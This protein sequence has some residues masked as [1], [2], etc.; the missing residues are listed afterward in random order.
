MSNTAR[1]AIGRRGWKLFLAVSPLAAL[2]GASILWQLRADQSMGLSVTRGK[3]I[4]ISRARLL[5]DRGIDVAGWETYC[6]ATIDD[7]LGTLYRRWEG[8]AA[9]QDIRRLAPAFVIKVIHRAPS[10]ERVETLLGAD[11]R[12]LGFRWLLP[13]GDLGPDPSEDEARRRARSALDSLGWLHPDWE[14]KDPKLET[15]NAGGHLVRQFEWEIQ[16]NDQINLTLEVD[17]GGDRIL[18]EAATARKAETAASLPG[19]S[20]LPLIIFQTLGVL[21]MGV[22][23][24]FC[25]VRYVQRTQQKEV[26][27]KR[28]LLIAAAI[29]ACYALM[30]FLNLYDVLAIQTGMEKPTAIWI[31]ISAMLVFYALLSLTCGLGWGAGEGDVRE[32]YPGKLTSVDVLTTGR[33]FSRNT[34]RAFLVGA[35]FGGWTLLAAALI[36]LPFGGWANS[37]ENP[38]NLATIIFSHVPSLF[39][40]MSPILTVP[41]ATISLVLP[42]TF[43]HRL[44]SRPLWRW[45]IFSVLAF[46]STVWMG[47]QIRPLPGGLLMTLLYFGSMLAAFLFYDLLAAVVT[48]GSYSLVSSLIALSAW[49]NHGTTAL[50]AGG[51]V[52]VLLAVQL[53]FAAY[54]RSYREE[55]VR[56]LYAEHL[57]HRQAMQAEVSAARQ[58]QLTLAPKEIPTLPGISIA[59]SCRPSR[60]V[61]GDFY[62]FYRIGHDRIGVFLA[63][64]GGSGLSSALSIA[65]AK[66]LLLPMMTRG[67]PSTE[68]VLRLRE[69]LRPI[70]GSDSRIGLFFATVDASAGTFSYARFGEFP[71]VVL[72]GHSDST[73]SESVYHEGRVGDESPLVECC[74]R[75]SGGETALVFTDGLVNAVNQGTNA[76]AEQWIHDFLASRAESDADQTHQA[77]IKALEPKVKKARRLGFDDDLSFVIVQ[78]DQL[79]SVRPGREKEGTGFSSEEVA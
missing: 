40:L 3:A 11:G 30:A 15:E 74:F 76:S 12:Y 1:H 61:G 29:F 66:G 73:A 27:H 60:T 79:F 43:A 53:Y 13:S 9:I 28:S 78:L 10:N 36:E 18:G 20:Q 64:G 67:L 52:G 31:G 45:L 58:A 70:L 7:S 44:A 16:P 46:F 23:V 35:A 33:L 6:S 62:D 19:D 59:A 69:S 38:T 56:P 42:L 41:L 17:V 39:V 49:S 5:H 55:E 77:F 68:V 54:G 8:D 75:L 34:S 4:A 48:F 57:A 25:L 22:L 51:V 14:I 63:E 21:G 65:F 2:I 72:A 47:T 24:V 50:V 37:G 26:S 71:K 32:A